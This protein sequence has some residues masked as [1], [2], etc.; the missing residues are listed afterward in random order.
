MDAESGIETGDSDSATASV[1]SSECAAAAAGVPTTSLRRDNPAAVSVDTALSP[2]AT[3]PCSD[4]VDEFIRR[5]MVQPPP[6]PVYFDESDFSITP[7]P[8][9]VV[10]HSWDL[11]PTADYSP[12]CVLP[13]LMEL[14]EEDATTFVLPSNYDRPPCTA[15]PP[16]PSWSDGEFTKPKPLPRNVCATAC[17]DVAAAC[18][19]RTVDEN[20]NCVLVSSGGVVAADGRYRPP[21]P[22]RRCDNRTTIANGVGHV[23]VADSQTSTTIENATLN[24]SA[25]DDKSAG[26]RPRSVLQPTHRLRFSGEDSRKKTSTANIWKRFLKRDAESG[27]MTSST[28]F[29]WTL[30]PQRHSATAQSLSVAESTAT[31]PRRPKNLQSTQAKVAA[32]AAAKARDMH[33]SAPFDFR[34]LKDARQKPAQRTASDELQMNSTDHR[35][36]NQDGAAGEKSTKSENTA[37]VPDDTLAAADASSST[38]GISWTLFRQR[39]S[40]TLPSSSIA[41]SAATLPRRPKILLTTATQSKIAAMAAEK[42]R[43]LQISAPFDF[44]DLTNVSEKLS[45]STAPD[46]D[47]SE[48]D[49]DGAHSAEQENNDKEVSS[50]SDDD[51]LVGDTRLET[52]STTTRYYRDEQGRLFSAA[53]VPGITKTVSF[54]CLSSGDDDKRHSPKNVRHTTAGQSNDSPTSGKRMSLTLPRLHKRNQSSNDEHLA[55]SQLGRDSPTTVQEP[56]CTDD[57]VS[58]VNRSEY[59]HASVTEE[60]RPSPAA[61]TNQ[62][63]RRSMTEEQPLTPPLLGLLDPIL[64]LDDDDQPSRT[65]NGRCLD[66]FRGALKPVRWS[67]D[68]PLPA[69]TKKVRSLSVG[70]VAIAGRQIPAYVDVRPPTTFLA[71]VTDVPPLPVAAPRSLKTSTTRGKQRPDKPQKVKLRSG[72]YTENVFRGGGANIFGPH[73]PGPREAATRACKHRTL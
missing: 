52:R 6:S 73:T 7:S 39:K 44:R 13:P 37:P 31:Y 41:E 46:V 16:P 20:A 66:T 42:G 2:D 56:E 45:L 19:E 18:H 57:D 67:A 53:A 59:L 65:V 11:P 63:L 64:T 12:Y 70:S 8:P 15:P 49:Q 4:D 17:V 43:N 38:T 1:T 68:D 71:A 72:A 33:I 32:L 55:T 10:D 21:L 5:M 29:T 47:R 69:S 24:D 54:P 60:V 30:F 23:D 48:V 28:G 25:S 51:D 62:L 9:D 14:P 34:D 58:E 3:T 27:G 40:A 22:M 26:A 61:S 35:D 36:V 50:E